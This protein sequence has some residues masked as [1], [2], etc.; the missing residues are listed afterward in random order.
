LKEIDETQEL[1]DILTEMF[2]DSNFAINLEQSKKEKKLFKEVEYLEIFINT[3]ANE[4]ENM[5][6]QVETIEKLIN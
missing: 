1:S 4:V 2:T 3:L 5:N 6:H